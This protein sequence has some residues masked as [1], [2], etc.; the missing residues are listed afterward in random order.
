MIQEAFRV[1]CIFKIL[2]VPISLMTSVNSKTGDDQL[3][4]EQENISK[5]EHI[6]Q[7]IT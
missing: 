3:E 7:V 2:A 6:H 5:Q 1:E 4:T